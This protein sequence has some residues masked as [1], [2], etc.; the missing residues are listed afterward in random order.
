MVHTG[1]AMFVCCALVAGCG[2]ATDTDA[3]KAVPAQVQLGDPASCI[4]AEGLDP[5]ELT[6]P[7]GS[8]RSWYASSR[9]GKPGARD[10]MVY[11]WSGAGTTAAQRAS[12]ERGTTVLAAKGVGPW[13]ILTF[14][15]KSAGLVSR[16]ADCIR[17]D[18]SEG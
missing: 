8:K 6:L 10:I 12:Q 15:P 3:T 7:G 9:V 18:D 2:A 16:V 4:R 1:L 5:E 14:E 11:E 17:G 13:V